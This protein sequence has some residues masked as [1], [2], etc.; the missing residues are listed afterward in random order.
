[1]KTESLSPREKEIFLFIKDYCRKNGYPPTVRE[2][3]DEVGLSSSCTVYYHLKKLEEKGAIHRHRFKPRAIEVITD[4]EE[5]GVTDSDLIPVPLISEVGWE[6]GQ[7]RWGEVKAYFS[8]PRFVLKDGIYF[9]LKAPKGGGETCPIQAGDLLMVNQNQTLSQ[10]DLALIW[11][12]AGV[13]LWEVNPEQLPANGLSS[14]KE[15]GQLPQVIGKIVGFWR[16]LDKG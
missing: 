3:G 12:E 10:G 9:L 4:K 16:T 2:I 11:L 15:G 13:H 14:P 6:S 1:M 5:T 8:L 7:L